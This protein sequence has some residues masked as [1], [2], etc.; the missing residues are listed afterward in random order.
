MCEALT[1]EEAIRKLS[2][3]IKGIRV[4]MLTTVT[5]RGWLRSRPMVAQQDQPFDGTLWFLSSAS[6]RKARDVRDR[7]QVN[8]CYVSTARDRYVSVSG[9]A[10]LL[11]DPERVASTWNSV[12]AEWFPK[13]PTDPDLVLIKVQVQEAEYWDPTAHRMAKL[14]GFLEP[15][16]AFRDTEP[17]TGI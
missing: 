11:A 10:A 16:A 2:E 8:L 6:T 5:E 15:T 7:Q 9:V 3:M 4:A 12:Y 14:R 13:G 1:R 17:G